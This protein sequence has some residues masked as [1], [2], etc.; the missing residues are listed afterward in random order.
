MITINR[1]QWF[2]TVF[3]KVLKQQDIIRQPLI[4][5]PELSSKEKDQLRQTQVFE[6]EIVQVLG[7]YEGFSLVR[8][9]EGTL[10]WMLSRNLKA[11]DYKK[12]EIPKYSI[13]PAAD[14]LSSW[15]GTIYE[16]GGLSKQGI[17]CS[18]FTQLYFLYVHG[19]ILPKNSKDQRKLGVQIS[20]DDFKDHDLVFCRP[21]T[22]PNSHHVAVCF[23]N[24]LWHS[25]R[26]GGVV[27]QTVEEFKREFKIEDLRRII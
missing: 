3:A 26:S 17:D 23:S 19:L 27:C 14:F 10:G 1:D 6:D 11:S 13:Q 21:L 9:Y 25:R 7:V 22:D 15:E 12:F 2:D 4:N 16:F 18:G 24:Q 5:Y 20:F 8:K